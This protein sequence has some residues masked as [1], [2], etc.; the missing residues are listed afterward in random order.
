[1]ERLNY[2]MYLEMAQ[3]Y[4]VGL[5]GPSGARAFVPRK[6]RIWQCSSKSMY[7]F[8]PQ[9]AFY[10]FVAAIRLR[11]CIILAGS[12]LTAPIA[13]VAAKI[14]G[15][16]SLVYLHGLDIAVEN[17]FYQG[18]W[19]PFFRHFDIVFVNSEFTKSL[20]A[21]AGIVT[22]KIVILHPGVDLP[23]MKTSQQ[24]RKI[25]RHHYH[26]GKNPLMLYVG[27]ITPRKGLTVFVKDILPSIIK[28]RFRKCGCC[29][30]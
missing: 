7:E 2:N 25:F 11:P 27:R 1:M 19:R 3:A 5:V 18:L 8:L 17:S 20:A 15:S 14:T 4:E 26:L 12:G 24:M 23:D 10:A 16:R 22:S 9:A 21:K 28:P 29:G 30:L 13:Y 6:A